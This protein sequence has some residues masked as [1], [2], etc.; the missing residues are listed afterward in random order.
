VADGGGRLPS[1]DLRDWIVGEHAAVLTRFE[2][3]VVAAVPLERWTEAVGEGG[4]SIAWLAF[5]AALH[6]D[7][8]VNAVL[9]GAAT[10]LGECRSALGLEAVPLSAGLGEAEQPDVTGSLHLAQLPA[11]VRAVH[12]TTSAWL[13]TLTDDDLDGLDAHGPAAL[14]RAGIDEADVP[15]LHRMWQGKPTAWFVQWEA[16]GHRL[17]H[18]G[19]MVSVRNRLGLSPF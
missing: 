12:D 3:S 19:E 2:Q 15:W 13:A 11:Y 16:I 1:V 5:H 14:E 10:V 4:S 7:L 18:L 6:E 8:A 9:R 17:T